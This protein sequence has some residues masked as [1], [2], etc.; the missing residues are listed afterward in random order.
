MN[1]S[2]CSFINNLSFLFF[3]GVGN[4]LK[5]LVLAFVSNPINT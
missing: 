3:K 5:S 4:E 2:V 1:N